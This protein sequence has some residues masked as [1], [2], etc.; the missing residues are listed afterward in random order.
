MKQ[1]VS[2]DLL[3]W[4][5]CSHHAYCIKTFA[6]IYIV[7]GNLVY[8]KVLHYVCGWHNAIKWHVVVSTLILCYW[9]HN[10]LS[11]LPSNHIADSH[12]FEEVP[13]IK[14]IITFGRIWMHLFTLC[15]LVGGH[16]PIYFTYS[17]FYACWSYMPIHESG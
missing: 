15:E 3:R 13:F 9:S 4:V 12:N 7:K 11:N 14:F 1:N 16:A 8:I 2:L 5:S 17:I 6:N 10:T